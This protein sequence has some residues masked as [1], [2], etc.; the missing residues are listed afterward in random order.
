MRHAA[1]PAANITF[2]LGIHDEAAQNSSPIR[3][4]HLDGAPM[5]KT[6]IDLYLWFFAALQEKA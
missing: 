3:F 5:D 2:F 1:N 4:C 6:K